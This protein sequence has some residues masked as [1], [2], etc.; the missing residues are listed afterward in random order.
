MFKAFARRAVLAA[1]ISAVAL[2]TMGFQSNDGQD[3]RVR[4]I[5]ATGVTMTHFYASNSG[6]NDWEEDILGQDVLRSGASV[7]INIDDGTGAC[8]YDF[9]AR[10]ADGDELVRYRIN[11]CQISE[12]RYTAG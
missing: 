8:I 5:N 7:V 3:R 4:I 11:V 10:F 1:A 9:K 12:Y 6:Q 2:G